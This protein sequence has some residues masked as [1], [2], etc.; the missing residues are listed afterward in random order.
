MREKFR[1]P[2]QGPYRVPADADIPVSEKN[3]FPLA[4]GRQWSEQVAADR[5][6]AT[7][8]CHLYRSGRTVNPEHGKS[9]LLQ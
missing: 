9:A 6:P 8:T 2:L 3:L 1:G 7:P 4:L 5:D